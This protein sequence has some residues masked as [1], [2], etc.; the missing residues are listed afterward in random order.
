MARILPPHVAHD[1][2]RHTPV[3]KLGAG[4]CATCGPI[5]ACYTP[6]RA[7]CAAD[8]RDLHTVFAF[9]ESPMNCERPNA[10]QA[11]R[12]QNSPQPLKFA[13]SH[14]V[15]SPFFEA[16][17][18]REVP[19]QRNRL[20]GLLNRVAEAW[21]HAAARREFERLDEYTLR[22][23]GIDRGEFDSFWAEAHGW[24]EPTRRRAG[25]HR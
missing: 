12:I 9:K 22:D 13:M 19:L 6:T 15:R 20:A 1:E 10:E 18:Q 11:L 25:P 23:L 14:A 17:A 5:Q 24:S 16:A 2:C 8:T 7:R 4:L 3:T 21:R